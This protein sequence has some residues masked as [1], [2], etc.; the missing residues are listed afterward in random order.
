MALKNHRRQKLQKYVIMET[1]YVFLGNGV[2]PCHN[3]NIANL[4]RTWTKWFYQS[5]ARTFR[6][7]VLSNFPIM[8]G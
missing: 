5:A 6:A 1:E 3:R 4:F 2:V 8:R 7:A